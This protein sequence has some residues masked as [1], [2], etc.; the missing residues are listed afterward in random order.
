[1]KRLPHQNPTRF[2]PQNKNIENNPMHSSRPA[3][4]I[5]DAVDRI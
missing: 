5:G 2:S 1:M 3:A 4:S